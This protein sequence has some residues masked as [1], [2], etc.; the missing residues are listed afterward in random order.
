MIGACFVT[1]CMYVALSYSSS[2]WNVFTVAENSL[3]GCFLF[4]LGGDY[5]YR[6]RVYFHYRWFDAN[7]IFF[8]LSTSIGALPFKKSI[9]FGTFF[10]NWIMSFSSFKIWFI[11]NWFLYFFLFF[12]LLDYLDYCFY[13]FIICEFFS[14]KFYHYSFYC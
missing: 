8:P 12:F 4:C 5:L 7:L 6:W 3:P 11:E 1:A 2:T 10:K 13:N 9:S 14:I